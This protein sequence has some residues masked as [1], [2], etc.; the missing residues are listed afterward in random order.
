MLTVGHAD[1]CV[2]SGGGNGPDRGFVSGLLLVDDDTCESDAGAVGREFGIGDP[3]EVEEILFG[4]RT[5]SLGSERLNG[6]REDE[7]REMEAMHTHG[8]NAATPRRRKIVPLGLG[9]VNGCESADEHDLVLPSA[10]RLS[11]CQL[12]RSRS[13]QRCR[14][15]ARRRERQ[16]ANLVDAAPWTWRPPTS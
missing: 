2:V 5:R 13:A 7:N 6:E 12:W 9:E 1:G 15:S 4:D 10:N 16:T 3:D 11:A 8:W 14:A